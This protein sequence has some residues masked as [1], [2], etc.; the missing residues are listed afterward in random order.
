MSRTI[1]PRTTLP[2]ALLTSSLLAPLSAHAN[3]LVAGAH[4]LDVPN[5]ADTGAVALLDTEAVGNQ[6]TTMFG[7]QMLLPPPQAGQRAGLAVALGDFNDDGYQD[8][9]VGVPLEDSFQPDTGG[10]Y[11]YLGNSMG[12]GG[13]T[14]MTASFFGAAEELGNHFGRALAVGDFDGDG[15]DDLAI[16]APRAHSATNHQS[17]LV[18][19]AYGSGGGLVAD[20]SSST[21]S[22]SGDFDNARFG[23]SLTTGDIESDGSDELAIGA[24]TY[25]QSG[26]TLGAVEVRRLDSTGQSFD[27][28]YDAFGSPTSCD[29]SPISTWFGWAL[30]FGNFD[31]DNELDLAIGAPGYQTPCY[32][33]RVHVLHTTAAD[34]ELHYAY[35]NDRFGYALAAG[36]LGGQSRDTLVVG[37]P[38]SSPEGVDKAGEVYVFKS[39]DQGFNGSGW[40]LDP[41]NFGHHANSQKFGCS[42]AVGDFGSG[43][44]DLAVGAK[45]AKDSRGIRTGGVFHYAHSLIPRGPMI[46]P[47]DDLGVDA[48]AG[49]LFGSSLAH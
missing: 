35:P 17:G 49:A 13:P 48:N 45:R 6:G 21:I 42:V 30:T 14:W 16:G 41:M 25:K 36:P 26:D 33:G 1:L 11:I 31:S 32:A 39:N 8:L 24:P 2:L 19:V 22:P 27:L 5:H 10:V 46:S 7:D 38:Q 37:A 20:P 43:T 34:Q 47:W 23:F 18:F 15:V 40:T 28:A 3:G 12:Y 4:R 44:I 9:A 29:G